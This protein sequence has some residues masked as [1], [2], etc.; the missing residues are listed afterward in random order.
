MTNYNES[1]GST[2][3]SNFIGGKWVPSN[4]EQ[5]SRCTI[6]RRAKSL[7]TCRSRARTRSTRPFAQRKRRSG[8]GAARRFRGARV[9]FKYQQLLVERWEEL[10]RIITQENG[11]SYPEAYGE[12]QRG[13]ECVEFA[14]GA[15]R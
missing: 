14:A 9:L 11:K 5:R 1:A 12:V 10:A 4:P 7:R 2:V 13:I 8:H 3:L 6:R 15:L